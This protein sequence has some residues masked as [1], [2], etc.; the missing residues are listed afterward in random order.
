MK[1]QKER[2]DSESQHLSSRG[3]EG[4]DTK[5][6][7][8]LDQINKST[9]ENTVAIKNNRNEEAEALKQAAEGHLGGSAQEESKDGMDEEKKSEGKPVALIDDSSP[10]GKIRLNLLEFA[11]K[12]LAA[13]DSYNVALS[14]K[15]IDGLEVRQHKDPELG[16]T[17]VTITKAKVPGLSIEKYKEFV[18][19]LPKHAPLLDKKQTYTMLEDIDGH[20][21]YHIHIKM[22]FPLTNRSIFNVC[23]INDLG[24]GSH[25]DIRSYQGSEEAIERAQGKKLHGKN[26]LA[27][28]YI[29]YRLL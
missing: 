27:T 4:V 5:S 2:Y 18:A 8:D 11:Q 20:Q 22:P 29:D 16:G 12:H 21:A 14:S 9:P 26:V 25:E 24:D 6:L 7:T 15:K 13:Y 23:H 10:F 19:E 28:N 1:E 17:M 3:G